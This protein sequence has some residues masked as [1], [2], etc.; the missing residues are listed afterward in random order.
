MRASQQGHKEV[1][2]LLI[3]HGAN[4][5]IQNKV[6]VIYVVSCMHGCVY[7]CAYAFKMIYSPVRAR[8]CIYVCVLTSF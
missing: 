8:V 6:S 2:K 7:G 5:D 4:K 3:D 1:A